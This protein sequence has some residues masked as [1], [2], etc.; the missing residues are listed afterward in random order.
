MKDLLLNLHEVVIVLTIL[1]AAVL[2]LALGVLP[3]GSKQS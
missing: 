1:E 2:C 3:G